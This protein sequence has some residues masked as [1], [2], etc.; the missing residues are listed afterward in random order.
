MEYLLLWQL[1]IRTKVCLPADKV[2]E[3]HDDLSGLVYLGHTEPNGTLPDKSGFTRNESENPQVIGDDYWIP[4]NT[5]VHQVIINHP[6]TVPESRDWLG[7]RRCPQG[8]I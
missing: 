4:S 2:H 1:L 3:L 6:H 5:E 8:H 7:K